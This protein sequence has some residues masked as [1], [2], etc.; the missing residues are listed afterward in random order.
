MKKENEKRNRQIIEE[1]DYL[2]N[3]ATSCDCTGLIPE[4]EVKEEELEAY[5]SLYRFGAPVIKKHP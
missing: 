1:Y 2:G 4:G 5:Q 3:A